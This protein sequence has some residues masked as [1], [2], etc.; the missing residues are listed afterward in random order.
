MKKIANNEAI[1]AS[2]IEEVIHVYNMDMELI[3][4]VFNKLIATS[5]RQ[6]RR[7]F[8][9]SIIGIGLAGS[10]YKLANKVVLLEEKVDNLTSK[11]VDIDEK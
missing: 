5:N 3:R 11:N 9:L 7:I 8:W 2:T 6:N 4:E 10:V 1:S